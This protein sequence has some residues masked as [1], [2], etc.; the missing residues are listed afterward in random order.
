MNNSWYFTSD[1]HL[2]HASILR[3]YRGTIFKSVEE[4]NSTI[5]NNLLTLPRGSNLMI[6]G[7]L[8][9]KFNSAQVKHFFDKFQRKKIN[10]H[11]VYGNHDKISWFNHK[12]IKS[13]GYMKVFS[14]DKQS[15]TICHYSMSVWNKSHYNAYMLYGH[16]H[17][18]D[19]TWNKALDLD[20]KDSSLQGKKLNINIELNEFKPWS[21]QEI[22]KYMESRGDNWDF[23][24]K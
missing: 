15:I 3:G 5:I 22:K 16:T 20:R 12:V 7:D 21:F 6:A 8:F 1:L 10:I 11:I 13:Q 9:W 2:S 24:Q 18:E 19:A 4:H 17:Y 14:I 23:I